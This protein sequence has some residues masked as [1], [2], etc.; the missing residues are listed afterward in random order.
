MRYTRKVKQGRKPSG[1]AKPQ[2]VRLYADDV[3]ELKRRADLMGEYWNEN[4]FIRQAV[5]KAIEDSR[6]I[7]TEL[8]KH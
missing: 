7:Y 8:L 6:S 4:E 3:A 1:L 2:L 5:R